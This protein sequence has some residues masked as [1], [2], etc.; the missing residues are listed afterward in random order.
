MF[1]T[2]EKPYWNHTSY[3]LKRGMYSNVPRIPT[4]LRLLLPKATNRLAN[5]PSKL[6][7]FVNQSFPPPL[8]REKISPRKLICFNIFDF[9]SSN[10]IPSHLPLVKNLWLFF[11]SIKFPKQRKK[12]SPSHTS[13]SC[14]HQKKPQWRDDTFPPPSLSFPFSPECR[15][16]GHHAAPQTSTDPGG[17]QVLGRQLHHLGGRPRPRPPQ[18]SPWVQLG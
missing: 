8:F 11:I 14:P 18:E 10:L 4:G 3:G 16:L 9:K 6:Y 2:P 7:T 5:F 15:R 1:I 13:T 12:P 17:F